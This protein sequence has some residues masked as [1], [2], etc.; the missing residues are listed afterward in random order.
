MVIS[1]I[2]F[3]VWFIQ[4]GIDVEIYDFTPHIDQ[5]DR[6][7]EIKTWLSNNKVDSYVVIDDKTS[8]IVKY[9]ENVIK[10][11]S[12]IGL[13]SEEYEEVMISFE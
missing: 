9:V 1:F 5:A 12:W 13:T 11:R 7:L 3:I 10:V 8:D 4:K 6:G 2:N